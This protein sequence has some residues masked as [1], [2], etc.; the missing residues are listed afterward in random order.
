M[1]KCVRR[2][3]LVVSSIKLKK[4]KP[5]GLAA[6]ARFFLF[7]KVRVLTDPRRFGIKL[8]LRR[9]I[10]LACKPSLSGVYIVPSTLASGGSYAS[11]GVLLRWFE[12]SPSN[13]RP[14]TVPSSAETESRLG[15]HPTDRDTTSV[16]G[17]VLASRNRESNTIAISC[18]LPRQ[19]G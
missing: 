4:P 17:L 19:A 7:G 15:R 3:L 9:L 12:L 5:S 18:C 8:L 11:G 6:L 14:D 16:L 1:S 10:P 2:T 13:R